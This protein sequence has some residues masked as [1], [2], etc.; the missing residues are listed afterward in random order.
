MSPC[1]FY[2]CMPFARPNCTMSVAKAPSKEEKAM[3]SP[4][5]LQAHVN[6]SALDLAEVSSVRAEREMELQ[7]SEKGLNPASHCSTTSFGPI[8]A[9]D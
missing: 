4:S 3:S 6:R 7:V 2:V 5:S 8:L 9:Q 1:Q